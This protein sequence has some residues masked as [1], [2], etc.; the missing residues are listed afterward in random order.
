MVWEDV[1]LKITVEL[2]GVNVPV[3]VQLPARLI[4]V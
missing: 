3:F 2:P 1:P 4:V